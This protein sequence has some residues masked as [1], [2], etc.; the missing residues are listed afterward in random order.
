MLILPD[1]ESG[2]LGENLLICPECLD[3]FHATDEYMMAMKLAAANT[4]KW[5]QQSARPQSP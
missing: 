4:W 5:R 3:R 2:P 1:S